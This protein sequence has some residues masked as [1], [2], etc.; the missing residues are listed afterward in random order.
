MNH[1]VE[2]IIVVN[3]IN[4]RSGSWSLRRLRASG[5]LLRGSEV[6]K[7][8]EAESISADAFF[9]KGS[10]WNVSYGGRSVCACVNHPYVSRFHKEWSA[11]TPCYR[12]AGER[13]IY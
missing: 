10:R 9:N 13:G 2:V 8:V 6:F 12:E 1:D 4:T 7:E 11:E 3:V 5:S